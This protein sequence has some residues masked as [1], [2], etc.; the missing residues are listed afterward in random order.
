VESGRPPDPGRAADLA[1]FIALLGQLRLWAGAPSFRT[2]AKRVGPLLR[3]PQTVSQSTVGDVFQARRRRLNPDLVVAIVRALVS[4][5]AVVAQWRAACISI[6]A[7]A[8]TGYH[9]GVLRQ[10]PRDLATFTGREAELAE[11]MSAV[12]APDRTE[13]GA[14]VVVAAI[15]G[16]AG[17][18]KTQLAV[19]AAHELVRAGRYTDVQLYVNLRGF[20]PERAL[21][22]P[23]A[24]L[25]SFLRQLGVPAQRIAEGLDERAAMFRDRLHGK[26]ALILLDN[27]ADEQQVRDLIPANPSCL[28]L[29][30]SRR[31]LAA[32]DGAVVHRLDV[33][34]PEEA[35]DL[36]ARI[37]GAERVA[38]EPRAAEQI[39]HACGRLPLAVCLAASK[40]RSRPTWTLAELAERLQR[41]LD[42]VSTG[43]RA[44]RPVFDLSYHGLPEQARHVFGLLGVHPGTD[45][46]ADAVAA[47]ADITPSAAEAMLALLCDEHLLQQKT[48]A[49][50]EMHDLLRTYSL[51][52]ANH[53]VY[54]AA[55][56]GVTEP[57]KVRRDAFS[58]LLDH[59]L[60]MTVKAIDLIS[61]T[62][63]R[64]QLGVPNR[65]TTTIPMSDTATARHWLAVERP[66]LLA[67]AARA[68]D[69][70]PEYVLALASALN[71]Y[72]YAQA[73]YA[74]V[75]AL[76]MNVLQA[77]A[78][79]K[80]LPSSA[81]AH[82]SIGLVHSRAGRFEEAFE[83]Y[84]RA[85]K[86]FGQIDDRLGTGRALAN[87]GLVHWQM[88]HYSKALEHQLR[89]LS[90]ARSVGDRE[91]EGRTLSNIG[92]V[93]SRMGRCTEALQNLQ[94]AL[95]IFA[96][97]GN[98]G[99]ESRALSNIGVVYL[100]QGRLSQALD[101]N[102]LALNAAR[103]AGDIVSEGSALMTIGGIHSRL[104]NH[105]M[106]L[107]H[108]RKSL[109]LISE[110]G[111]RALEAAVL[112]ELGESVYVAEDP[113]LAIS[114]HQAALAIAD[115]RRVA[116]EQGRA[117]NG[118][119]RSHQA[120]GRLTEACYHSE[121]ALAVFTDIG[122][123]EAEQTRDQLSVIRRSG[124]QG[125]DQGL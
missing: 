32:L 114:H 33:F 7:G 90:M 52:I 89:A 65:R 5:E 72:L 93:H 45:F 96:A 21:A 85:L 77:A 70:W 79:T 38:A 18:G 8:K 106:A 95:S 53:N 75:E 58:R 83:C 103:E 47:L 124:D 109:N 99:D 26:D 57:E 61:Q 46:H 64:Q 22:D 117:H 74:D 122:V 69:E 108:L 19:H 87:I 56:Q 88:G 92:L 76:Q 66:N 10:L 6:H 116:Y 80:D 107:E 118:L 104:G 60:S 34:T 73:R 20:D 11:L 43:G 31:T 9:A 54:P 59:Y 25:D 39:V 68:S 48:Q 63:R 110:A 15:E 16:M 44:L 86:V 115:D 28:V 4:D 36:L 119:A 17:V 105:P 51:E 30:T 42:A 91:G 81:S 111:E 41:G 3:P 102:Q 14:A 113:V 27:A 101:H 2:L 121:S 97:I 94:A 123:P 62:L 55:E 29:I 78:R 35:M 50:Y 12:D 24:V 1:E 71:G 13:T 49:R 98:R 82:R 84:H 120:L 125:R 100:R 112:N 37:A 40:L 23:A 67:T